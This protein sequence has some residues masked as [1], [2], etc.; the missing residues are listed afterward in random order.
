M[1][2][3]PVTVIGGGLAGMAACIYLADAGFK[4][5]CI[6]ADFSDHDPVGESLDWSAPALLKSLGL[7][8]EDLLEKGIATYKLHVVLK[9][10]D[11]SEQHYVPGEWLGKPP[12]NVDLRTLHV[13]RT[14]L[15]QE[16]RERV[17]EKGVSVVRDKVAHVETSGRRVIAIVTAAGTRVCSP[18]SST[19]PDRRVACFPGIF[20][21]PCVNLVLTK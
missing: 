4:V 17:L 9:L 16:V 10:K 7:P 18:C 19:R 2:E 15:N 8:M 3:F 1:D 5:L 12:F 20:A 11:G 6:D 13:D 14:L 21:L